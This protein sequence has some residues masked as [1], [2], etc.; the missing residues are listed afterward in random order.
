MPGGRFQSSCR[1]QGCGWGEDGSDPWGWCWG[2]DGTAPPGC[3]Q[4]SFSLLFSLSPRLPAP[5]RRSRPRWAPRQPPRGHLSGPG[6][7]GQ[8]PR[9][10]PASVKPSPPSPSTS[11]SCASTPT[12]SPA[13]ARSR[14]SPSP[15]TP[16]AGAASPPPRRTSTPRWPQPRGSCPPCSRGVRGV[17]SPR[18]P[19]PRRGRP[20]SLRTAACS[21]A[22][23]AKLPG[24]G[25]PRR[26][27]A[28][29][30]G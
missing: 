29:V 1:V 30:G 17:P 2:G 6:A 3:P 23:P 10:P 26:L 27:P 16:W 18:C 24:G 20:P 28:W 13:S 11:S 7:E 5:P 8:P 14:R 25:S 4:P 12:P 19:P 22:S 9:V 15:S 21:A